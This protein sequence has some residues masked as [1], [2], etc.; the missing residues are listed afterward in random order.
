MWSAP[1][2]DPFHLDEYLEK[3]IFLAD[4]N[5]ERSAKNSTYK[6]HITSLHHMLLEYSP[7]DA[8]VIPN[9]SP[10]F[11]FFAAND[12]ST[13]VPLKQSDFFLSDY[14]GVRALDEA[15]RLSLVEVPCGHQDFPRDDCKQ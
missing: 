13:V 7:L 4:I 12:T 9:S 8:I 1:S 14:I 10:W 5:N 6:A 11:Q 2:Q 15:G 3:S